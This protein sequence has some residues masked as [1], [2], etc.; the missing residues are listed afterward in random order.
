MTINYLGE[1]D[2]QK[3]LPWRILPNKYCYLQK[4]V[5]DDGGKPKRGNGTKDSETFLVDYNKFEGFYLAPVGDRP[6]TRSGT[7]PG[8]PSKVVDGIS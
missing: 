6:G 3:I 1:G 4:N 7:S 2:R 5:F 8:F